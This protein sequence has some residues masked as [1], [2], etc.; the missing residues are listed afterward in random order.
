MSRHRAICTFKYGLNVIEASKFTKAYI[1]DNF[2]SPAGFTAA[3][4]EQDI[5][6][7]VLGKIEGKHLKDQL[8][9]GNWM[10]P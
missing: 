2:T 3:I 5:H 6:N 10:T 4:T 8:G 1:S 7:T 9:Y